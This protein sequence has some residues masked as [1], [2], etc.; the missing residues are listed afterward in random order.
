MKKAKKLPVFNQKKLVHDLNFEK[1]TFTSKNS[2]KDE[3]DT[4]A[5]T[6]YEKVFISEEDAGA[7]VT[8]EINYSYQR[9]SL[10]SPWMHFD[11]C[12]TLE[13]FDSNSIKLNNIKNMKQLVAFI[14][15]LNNF[16]AGIWQAIG[17]KQ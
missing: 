5:F 9:K 17:V 11:T 4:L 15:L 16:K 3:V 1:K 8:L 14:A 12:V 13:F 7:K 2:H 6:Q 10:K